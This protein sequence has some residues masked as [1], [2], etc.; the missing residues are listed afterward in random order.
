MPMS[1][2]RIDHS[3]PE[4]NL[5]FEVGRNMVA[6]A[7]SDGRVGLAFQPIF[8]AGP[9]PM[10]AFH[11]GLIRIR[12]TDG[13]LVSAAEF[14][15]AVENTSLVQALDRIALQK[16][17]DMLRVDPYQRLSINMSAITIMDAEWMDIMARASDATPHIADRLIVEI[18]ESASMADAD[19]T[20]R[21]MEFG[22]RL[23]CC[24]A[25]DDFGAGFTSFSQLRRFKFDMVKIDGQFIRGLPNSRDNQVLV[26][27]LVRIS[28]QFEMFTVAEFVETA[29]E[30]AM[31]QQMGID[32]LQGFYHGR[33]ADT[34]ICLNTGSQI[35]ALA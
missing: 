11:E 1:W 17:L 5:K 21:F 14:I 15:P 22:H 23:G 31:A 24:F 27:A 26:D 18:T 6:N 10:I 13:R 29:E 35:G 19:E 25:I 8:R 30:S 3:A 16:A 34:P 28:R 7:I 4:Q 33:S 32:G 12:N 20:A 9:R 2:K